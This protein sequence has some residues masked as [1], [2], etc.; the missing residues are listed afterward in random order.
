MFGVTAVGSGPVTTDHKPH[1]KVG[2]DRAS[3]MGRN[4]QCP[5]SPWARRHQGNNLK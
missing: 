3:L 2:I 5:G 4:G 1:R